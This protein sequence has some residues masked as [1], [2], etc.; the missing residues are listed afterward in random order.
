MSHARSQSVARGTELTEKDGTSFMSKRRG[1]KLCVLG[2]YARGL[3]GFLLLAEGK[4]HYP[5]QVPPQ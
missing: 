5:T 1:R 3:K 4:M 2:A